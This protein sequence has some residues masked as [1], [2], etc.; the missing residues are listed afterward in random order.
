MGDTIRLLKWLE[1]QMRSEAK[2]YEDKWFDD[3]D[4]SWDG[5]EVADIINKYADKIR[6]MVQVVEI[7]FGK[8]N[9][10]SEVSNADR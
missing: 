2:T 7:E 3:D 8:L 9:K 4:R 10:E 6:K 1:G 5:H